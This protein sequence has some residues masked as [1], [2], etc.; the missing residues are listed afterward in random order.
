[1]RTSSLAAPPLRAGALLLAL[2]LT[3]ALAPAAGALDNGL[4][5]TPP[6]G[7]NSWYP[8]HCRVNEQEVLANAQALVSSGMA[9]AGYR[10]V[11]VDGCWEASRRDASGQLAA[12]PTTFPDGIPQL[13][14]EVHSLGLKL[15]I[16]TSAGRKICNHD[17]PGSYG[18]FDQ[19]MRTFASWGVD[20]VKVD[21]C[22]PAP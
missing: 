7:W 11:N 22:A 6:L 19:D 2:V 1:M 13:A 8:F 15:G 14:R 18:H 9:A 16:Y 4:A 10:Y 17:R 3:L 20:Y 12:D 5:R 21:W